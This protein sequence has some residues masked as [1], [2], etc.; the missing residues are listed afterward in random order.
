MLGDDDHGDSE[1]DHHE[2]R[3][4]VRRKVQVEP[5]DPHKHVGRTANPEIRYAYFY[6]R[7]TAHAL[8]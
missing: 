2:E 8:N 3:D 1:R 5:E 4:V 6:F 7:F